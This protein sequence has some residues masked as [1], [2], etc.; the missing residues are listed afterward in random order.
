METST[1]WPRP[2]LPRSTS[3][4]STPN[5]ARLHAYAD[6]LAR[7]EAGQDVTSDAAAVAGR[8]A[9]DLYAARVHR[10][11]QRAGARTRHGDAA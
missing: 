5:A 6:T 2:V 3:A 11:Q 1:N 8:A 10:R 7:R 4:A 9:A